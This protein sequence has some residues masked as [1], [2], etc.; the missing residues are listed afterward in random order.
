MIRSHPSH[1]HFVLSNCP[2]MVPKCVESYQQ[3]SNPWNHVTNAK[4]L[5]NILHYTTNYSLSI[6]TT[7]END[8][9]PQNTSSE[10]QSSPHV[11]LNLPRL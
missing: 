1:I 7:R 10:S 2:G 3:D 4:A 5:K 6:E 11:V 8:R 9:E